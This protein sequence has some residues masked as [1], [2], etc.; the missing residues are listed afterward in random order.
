M[1]SKHKSKQKPQNKRE[2]IA[3]GALRTHLLVMCP[4]RKWCFSGTWGFGTLGHARYQEGCW[5]RG[6]LPKF[7]PLLQSCEDETIFGMLLAGLQH[8]AHLLTE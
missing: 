4:Q 6:D 7:P 1:T 3:H 8:P 2:S 5:R